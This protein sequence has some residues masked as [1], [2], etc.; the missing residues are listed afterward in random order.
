MKPRPSPEIPSPH[1]L[2]SR[3]VHRLSL[4]AKVTSEENRND[5]HLPPVAN[6][7]ETL[8]LS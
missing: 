5:A 7:F 8:N 2:E 6:F 1:F 3:V 4:W